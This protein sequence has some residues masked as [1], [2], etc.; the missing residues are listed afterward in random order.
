MR[1]ERP[2][3][4]TLAWIVV[5]MLAG[6]LLI[7]AWKSYSSGQQAQNDEALDEQARHHAS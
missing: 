6:L 1:P 2:F 4:A 7:L 3:L 5:G